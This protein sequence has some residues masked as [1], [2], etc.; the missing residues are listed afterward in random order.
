[1][2]NK[3]ISISHEFQC[4]ELLFILHVNK[5]ANSETCVNKFLFILHLPKAIKT[6][7]IKNLTYLPEEV[8]IKF[9]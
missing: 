8:L 4:T 5:N 2:Y 6:W 7:Q 3:H 9:L 1:M